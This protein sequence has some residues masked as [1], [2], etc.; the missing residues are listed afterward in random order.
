MV[1]LNRKS[2]KSFQVP[3]VLFLL[4]LLLSL[5]FVGFSAVE[6][7]ENSQ[8]DLGTHL[9]GAEISQEIP[10]A[11]AHSDYWYESNRLSNK[12]RSFRS[13]SKKSIPPAELRSVNKPAGEDERKLLPDLIAPLATSIP[14]ATEVKI[15]QPIASAFFPFRDL[16]LQSLSTVIL[17]N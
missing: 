14:K 1:S 7:G 16:A 12:D 5:L 17:L 4:T 9:E 2:I 8:H 6:G 15:I 10:S 3:G 13:N 11:A